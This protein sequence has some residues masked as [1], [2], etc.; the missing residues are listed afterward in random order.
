LFKMP[1]MKSDD[2]QKRLSRNSVRYFS[3]NLKAS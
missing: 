2:T 1:M 3:Q